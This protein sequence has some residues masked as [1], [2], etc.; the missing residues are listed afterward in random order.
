MTVKNYTYGARVPDNLDVV[1]DQIRKAH[2]YRNRICAIELSHRERHRA[3][4]MRLCPEF[5][6]LSDEIAAVESQLGAARE[7]IQAAKSKQ[8]T[9]TPTGVD[10]VVATADYCKSTLKQLQVE[11]KAEKLGSYE[12]DAVRAA[13]LGNQA[14]KA[15][16]LAEA[17]A[18]AGLYWGTEALVAA[19]CKTFSSKSP[20]RFARW[21]G[22]GQLAVQL[23]KGRPVELATSSDTRFQL[24]IPDDWEGRERI[25]CLI[26]V[27]SEP[28]G[29]PVFARVP[30]R[31]HR[32]LPPG[33][34]IKWAYLEKRKQANKDKWKIRLSIDIPDEEPP[35]PNSPM[36]AIHVG[37]R[38]DDDSLRVATWLGSDGR[39]G[40][41]GMPMSHVEQYLHLDEASAIRDVK[42]NEAISELKSFL[43]GSVPDWLVDRTKSLHLW[44]SQAR[45][46]GLMRYWRD[47]RFEGDGAIYDSLESWR[48][49]DKHD[50]QH[51][52]RLALRL[53]R[54]RKNHYRV[55]LRCLRRQY[56]IVTIA[57][58]D[59]AELMERS[60]PEDLKR[61]NSLANRYAG[62]SASS[63]FTD[64]IKEVW[65]LAWI[66]ADFKNISRQC[67]NCG[68]VNDAKFSR[69]KVTCKGCKTEYDIDD[70]GVLHTLMRGETM[71]KS[72]AL[73][74]HLVKAQLA[75]VKRLEKQIKMQEGRRKKYAARK[76]EQKSV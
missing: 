65:P 23:Q 40:T 28:N 74:E 52:R 51:E 44:K 63:D 5:A 16:E 39:S 55:S 17:K 31:L 41:I 50:W 75:S 58:I 27:M 21:Q 8:R 29:S 72:G 76:A 53:V 22:E 1:N 46:A 43:K 12:T 48:K 67:M 42:L 14:I 4:L 20:P 24:L 62:I 19:S 32:P 26:R 57:E 66:N 7:A 18:S 2:D 59:K 25:D 30:I 56:P 33:G 73:L 37:W 11:L 10:G 15:K 69:W 68:H 38:K 71:A 60:N 36:V 45:L 34:K 6:R 9:K 49:T 35:L 47:N 61:D 13:I 54:R 70:N 3:I 64:I